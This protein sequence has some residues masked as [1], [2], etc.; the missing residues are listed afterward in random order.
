MAKSK[1]ARRTG[2]RLEGFAVDLGTVLGATAAKADRWISQRQEIVR[3][4]TEVR[5]TATKLLADLGHSAQAVAVSLR[6]AGAKRRKSALF[7]ATRPII[8]AVPTIVR[9]ATSAAAVPGRKRRKLSAK[10]RKA[11][12]DAQKARW[13]KLKA[14]KKG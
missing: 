7:A 10:G 5:D 4:L 6:R 9:R 11:I 8:R 13:A 2:S 12:S 14:T 3:Q 1:G